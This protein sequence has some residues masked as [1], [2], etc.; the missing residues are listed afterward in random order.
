MPKF[1]T[2]QNIEIDL[3]LGSLGDRIL[4]FIIDFVILIVVMI[5]LNA[6]LAYMFSGEWAILLIYIPAMF[7]SFAFE[8]FGGGQTPGKRAMNIKV[9]KLD[10][11]T[12]TIGSY[13]LRWLFRIIDLW[14]YPIV[15]A[16]AVISIIATKNGQRIGDLVA[17]TTVI[18]VR[19]VEVAQAFKSVAKDD[20]QVT[21]SQ[22][23][24][25]TDDQIELI[26]KALKMRKEGFSADGVT[27]LSQKI[28][29]KL[30]IESELPDV[31]FL[32]T[33][34]ADYE[35]LANQTFGT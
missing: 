8:Y 28:K 2:N 1:V 22:V 12:P 17:G 3:E 10:G 34:I 33:I 9:V 20:H 11:T 4:A 23:K 18:K 14:L 19:K 15:F 32:Y 24:S 26:K 35:Y 7:Y 6:S 16:P 31:K 29:E 27:V 25:L 5:T 21:F 13:L 30:N